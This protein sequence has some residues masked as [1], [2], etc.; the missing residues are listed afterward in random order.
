MNE[1]VTVIMSAKI[2]LTKSISINHANQSW[3]VVPYTL[4]SIIL[5]I[6]FPNEFH[7]IAFFGLVITI[8]ID[9]GTR[10]FAE[11]KNK[12]KLIG[13]ITSSKLWSGLSGKLFVLII[14]A[15]L[16]GI[17]NSIEALSLISTCLFAV[18]YG[19]LILREFYSVIENL[20]DA[21]YT[22]VDI[23]LQIIKIKENQL[24]KNNDLEEVQDNKIK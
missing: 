4:L 20:Y 11:L 8:L 24:L 23:F 21:G 9:T 2:W 7:I 5:S 19:I 22:Q 13:V 15:L 1:I 14:L 6:L 12:R 16:L 10:I 18:I 17:L 3:L